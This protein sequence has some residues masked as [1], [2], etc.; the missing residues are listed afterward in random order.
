M[1]LFNNT[2]ILKELDQEIPKIRKLMQDVLICK[3]FE[4]DFARR[5][6]WSSNALEG[7]TLSLDETIALIDY[8]EVC[9]GHT[10]SEYREAKALYRSINTKLIPLQQR[11]IS[12]SW[13]L[14]ANAL[15]LESQ[16]GYRTENVYIGSMVEAVYYPPQW[17]KIP[18][19][20]RAFVEQLSV[21]GGS[22]AEL[23]EKIAKNHMDFERMHP[24]RDG[25]GRTGRMLLNQ[26]LMNEGYLPIVIEP[27]G[28]YR[29]AFR[30]YD[31]NE[32]ASQMVHL[33]AKGEIAAV[34][35]VNQLTRRKSHP[36]ADQF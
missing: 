35:R 6:C 2:A 25:N 32:D 5:F 28:G 23:F 24:F 36:Q 34:N 12:E 15:L 3:P 20:M 9:G 14:E 10:F 4:S 13:I 1:A 29:Q 31:R 8:D 22:I 30:R 11:T 16:E 27:Q 17:K 26:Q 18:E 21:S 7:N 19:L 33:L